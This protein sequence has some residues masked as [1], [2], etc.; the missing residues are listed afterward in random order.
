MLMHLPLLLRDKCE[1]PQE[2]G[3]IC[4]ATKRAM[5]GNA[6]DLVN[7]DSILLNYLELSFDSFVAQVFN[8]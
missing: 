4:I 1:Q 2:T 6:N 7:S 8:S 3:L 5:Q